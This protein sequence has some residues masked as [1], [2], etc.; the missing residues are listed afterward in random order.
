MP[1]PSPTASASTETAEEVLLTTE[2][3]LRQL[4]VRVSR[5]HD[6]W[7]A[8]QLLALHESNEDATEEE[9]ER[10]FAGYQTKVETERAK[11][12][13]TA[14]DSALTTLQEKREAVEAAQAAERTVT[15]S[16]AVR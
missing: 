7:A 1:P 13:L 3:Q 16:S 12:P 10:A 9:Y 4:R 11:L 15:L 2:Q 5:S 6:R 8:A 14:I